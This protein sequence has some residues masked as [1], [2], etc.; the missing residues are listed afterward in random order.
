MNW[1]SKDLLTLEELSASEINL[2]LDTASSLKEVSTR[3]VKK[4]PALRGRTVVLFFQEPSTRTRVSFELA[5][6][7]MS[8]DILNV[9]TASSSLVKGETL[10]DTV[11]TLEAMTIDAIVVRHACSGVP[12]MLSNVLK[13]SVINAGDGSHEHP[14]QGLLDLYTMR[15]HKGKIEGLTVTIVGDVSHSRVARSNI[16]GLLKLGAR[17]RVC[18][19]PTLIP[20]GIEKMGVEVFHDLDKG[21]EGA[22]VVNVLRL[23]L[24][25]QKKNLFPT[26]RE[27]SM[28]YSVTQERLKRAK[29]DVIVMHPGPMNRGVE[30]SSGVADGPASVIDEQVTNGVAV[31]MAV[32][33]LLQG[34]QVS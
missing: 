7:R 4:V 25:R 27:Y 14:T 18:A 6:K 30:I 21:L 9:Q 1:K 5:A 34:E 15:E 8:A 3:S 11:K 24:E 2:I 17:V 28:L 26:I 23:Q 33:Y 32:L 20:A 12:Q 13:A 22:D 31:R 10:I 29:K 19:P 16:H